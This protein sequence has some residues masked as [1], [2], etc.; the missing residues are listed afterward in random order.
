M[1]VK[2]AEPVHLIHEQLIELGV[3]GAESLEEFHPSVRDRDDVGVLRCRESGVIVLD[4]TDHISD[5]YYA[6]KEHEVLGRLGDRARVVASLEEDTTRRVEQWAEVITNR[7]WLDV[8]TG[9]GAVL[10]AMGGRARSVAAVEPQGEFQTLLQSQGHTVYG[11]LVEVGDSVADV[12]T[13]FHVFEHLADPLGGLAECRRIL[14]P[15]GRIVIE[16]PHA[17]DFLLDFLGSKSFRSFTLWGEHLLLHTRESLRRHLQHSGFGEIT[18][19]GFQR[20][21]LA[22]HL[23]WLTREAPG[24]HQVWTSLRDEDLD[25]SYAG[26]LGRLDATDTLIA[27]AVIPGS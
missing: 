2:S 11:S 6:D 16:V 14:A 27:E 1:A 23:H 12:V 15:G 13:M 8:G 21:P 22:N 9:A 5:H 3:C 7:R 24:G 18:I 10:E 25:H 4:R 20:Y 17:R 19:R 26:L